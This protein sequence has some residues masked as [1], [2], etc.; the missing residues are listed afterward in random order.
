MHCSGTC[1]FNLTIYLRNIS[2]SGYRVSSFFFTSSQHHII[3]TYHN[4][5]KCSIPHLMDISG[6]YL[7]RATLLSSLIA[8]SNFSIGCVG[9]SWI[10]ISFPILYF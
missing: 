8:C 7:D 4:L 5:F 3:W 9:S 2:M 10:I 1:F 6:G